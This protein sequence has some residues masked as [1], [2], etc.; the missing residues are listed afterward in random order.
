MDQN[1]ISLLGATRMVIGLSSILKISPSNFQYAENIKILGGS[2]TV[3]VIPPPI[4]LSGSSATGW[5][6]GYPIGDS[7]AISIEGGAVLYLAATS[8]TMTVG[9]L[10]GYTSGATIRV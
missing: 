8:A 1:N 2:G 6:T 7:E 9:M 10:V 5:G 3:E 4:A